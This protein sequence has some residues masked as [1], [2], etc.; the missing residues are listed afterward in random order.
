[1]ALEQDDKDWFL[2][3]VELTVIKAVAP[4]KALAD[5]HDQTLYGATG[6]NGLNSYMKALSSRVRKLEVIGAIAQAGITAFAM[7]HDKLF[8][9]K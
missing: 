9:G 4:I 2:Q 7:F 8:G 1:M 3:S 5:K 6:D